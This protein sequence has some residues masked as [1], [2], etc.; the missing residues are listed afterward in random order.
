[1]NKILIFLCLFGIYSNWD[2]ITS[3]FTTSPIEHVA[4]TNYSSPKWLEGATGYQEALATS[5][6]TGAPIFLYIHTDWCGYC[7]KFEKSLLVNSNVNLALSNFIKVKL[8][9]ED[10]ADE[11]RIHLSLGGG[12]YPSIYS[13]SPNDSK[14]KRE[15]GPFTRNLSGWAM[16]S[17]N[18]FISLLASIVNR[19]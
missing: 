15:K 8:N 2:S 18:E 12:G 17:E 16:M 4:T 13:L 3:P 5:R 9:P 10:G 11:K 7:K 1:M 14:A 19:L 6:N